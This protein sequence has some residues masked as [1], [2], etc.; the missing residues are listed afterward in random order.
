MRALRFQDRRESPMIFSNKHAVFL[1]LALK[2]A[3]SP[4]AGAAERPAL[5]VVV[6]VDQL[7]Y[8]YLERFHKNYSAQGVFRRCETEGA[9]MTNCRHR[10]AFTY[11]APGHAVQLTGCYPSEHGIIENDWFD[12]TTG[13]KTYCVFDPTVKL[14]GT[15]IED[16]TVS[17]R[18]MYADTLGDRLKLLS[19]GKSKVFAVAIKDRAS[20]LMA[21]HQA[22][23]A[24]WMSNDG[25]WITSDYYRGGLPKYVE[26]VNAQG[27]VAGYAGATWDRILP[28]ESYLHGVKENSFGE[29][30]VYGVTADFPHVLPKADDKNYIKQ[31]AGSPFGN[32]STL[33]VASRVLVE[34]KLGL[35]AHPDILCV[36]C[37]SNDYVGHS[38]GPQSL[39]VEDI[40]YRTDIALGKFIDFIDSQLGDRPW[41]FALTADHAVSPIPE[42]MK[43]LGHP[44]GRDPFGKADANGTF[45]NLRATLEVQLRSKL[46]VSLT[47]ASEQNPLYMIQAVTD[48]EVYLKREHPLIQGEKFA[49]AQQIIRDQLLENPVVAAA[50]TRD[51]M[52]GGKVATKLDAMFR[53]SFNPHRSGDVLFALQP[54][55]QHGSAGTTHGSPWEYDTHVPLLLLARGSAKGTF[56]TGRFDTDT[57]PAMLCPTLAKVLGIVPPAMCC[58]QPI[59]EVLAGSAAAKVEPVRTMLPVKKAGGPRPF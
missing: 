55:Y 30:P 11:T 2:T 51:Q 42:L 19:G 52:L 40:T 48:N 4:L 49:I 14:L 17:P 35:D 43:N 23:A 34:E 50:V 46:G 26:Q 20:I 37:T 24:I 36:N 29:R 59:D 58:E 39:E 22:D 56:K 9:W 54:Y 18:R 12:R 15:T 38:F 13:K 44:A 57:S 45:D 47:T 8:E 28:A 27:D 31:L 16:L 10:H 21:G 5:V 53:R 25:K 1:L 3:I 7:C 6:S 32:E 41:V 33:A